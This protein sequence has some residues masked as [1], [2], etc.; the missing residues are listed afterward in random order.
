MIAAKESA[1][2][3]FRA[4]STI[5]E[6]GSE[7]GVV[8]RDEE[9]VGLARITLE[10]PEPSTPFRQPIIRYAITCGIYGWL[11]HTRFF[12]S[13][14]EAVSA[15][16]AMKPELARISEELPEV[17]ADDPNLDEKITAAATQVHGFTDRFP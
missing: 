2:K 11:V 4:G 15:Y 6:I 3:P 8:L 10:Q 9:Y 13:E 1:W 14:E 5:G 12:S 7:A 17:S 16:D